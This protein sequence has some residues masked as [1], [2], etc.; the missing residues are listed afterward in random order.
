MRILSH[1]VICF[2]IENYIRLFDPKKAGRKRKKR[3]A[4]LKFSNALNRSWLYTEKKKD[5]MNRVGRKKNSV[6]SPPTILPQIDSS[7]TPPPITKSRWPCIHLFLVTRSFISQRMRSRAA[8]MLR[9]QSIFTNALSLA[10]VLIKAF[11]DVDIGDL[12]V[13]LFAT[14]KTQKSKALLWS[15]FPLISISIFLWG[16]AFYLLCSVVS[17]RK[18]KRTMIFIIWIVFLMS[19]LCRNRYRF[20]IFRIKNFRP[21]RSYDVINVKLE[22]RIRQNAWLFYFLIKKQFTE[23]IKIRNILNHFIVVDHSLL[24]SDKTTV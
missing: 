7:V 24:T 6:P 11:F 2:Q 14:L 21:I 12:Q 1:F 19:C 17:K 8:R 13:V 4:N 23:N 18:R 16:I 15:V 22:Y 20:V 10:D 5:Q 9:V 3:N